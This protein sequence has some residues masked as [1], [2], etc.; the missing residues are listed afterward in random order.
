MARELKAQVTGHRMMVMQ[1]VVSYSQ[2]AL[3]GAQGT[4]LG[5]WEP[6]QFPGGIAWFPIPITSFLATTMSFFRMS[7]ALA[8]F[9]SCSK[10]STISRAGL[11]PFKSSSLLRMFVSPAGEWLFPSFWCSLSSWALALLLMASRAGVT[12]F[13]LFTLNLSQT[14]RTVSR[15]L[16]MVRWGAV[17][18]LCESLS[19]RCHSGII[20]DYLKFYG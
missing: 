16:S 5:H 13:G 3:C 11:L 9:N 2:L 20:Q 7:A 10:L 17:E 14:K 6:S 18:F 1:V 19:F 12:V 15:E 4:P 8:L